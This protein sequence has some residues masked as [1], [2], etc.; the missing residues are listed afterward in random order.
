MFCPASCY[1]GYELLRLMVDNPIFDIEE[2]MIDAIPARAYKS[3]EKRG[4][5]RM[6]D[7]FQCKI[8][9]FCCLYKSRKIIYL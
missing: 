3:G 8:W 5:Q 6:A 4:Q 7:E 9:G 2:L 1:S